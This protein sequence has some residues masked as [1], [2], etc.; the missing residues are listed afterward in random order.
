MTNAAASPA[1]RFCVEMLTRDIEL[2]DAIL[3]LID[4]CVDGAIRTGSSN[5]LLPYK[6]FYAH[7]ELSPT[8]F[9]ISDNC[10]GIDRKLAETYAFRFGR[11]DSDRDANLATVGVYGIGMKRAIFKLG[12]NCVLESKHGEDRFSVTIDKAWMDNDEDWTLPMTET[13]PNMKNV[14]TCIKMDQL[15]PSVQVA[16]DSIK[17]VF[18]ENFRDTVK[19]HYSYI[20]EKGFEVKIN[21]KAI[22]LETLQTLVDL[23]KLLTNEGGIQPYIYEAESHGV[24]VQVV[25]GL[26]EKLP[27]DL[28]QEN[29]ETGARNKEN[30]GWTIVCN[31]RVVVAADKTRLTGWGEAGVP[32]YHSQFTALAGV[33]IFKSNDPLLLPVT[34]TKRGI[35]QNSEIYGQVK[36]V[37]REALKHFTNFTNKWK[38]QSIERDQIQ[39]QAAT[40]DIRK[41]TTSIPAERWKEVRKGMGGKRFVPVLPEPPMENRN[42]RIQF[43]KPR[44]EIEAVGNY[45]LEDPKSKPADVGIASFE[46]ALQQALKK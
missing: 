28:D 27:S 21:G 34:T 26:Y 30:A 35:D 8:S 10:G 18:V 14:G 2:A 46:W 20:L 36:E 22:R 41:A 15:H 13:A 33:V 44:E 42:Q 5:S 7:I 25:M 6:G 45:L 32:A 37:M 1:K 43:T 40:M 24:F 16:F 31:D 3:D 12:T 19:R 17:G 23:K 4:N 29:S 9:Q 38:G 11:R 39:S